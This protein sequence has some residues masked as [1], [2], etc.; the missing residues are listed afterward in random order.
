M[1]ARHRL[2]DLLAALTD[3]LRGSFLA[4]EQGKPAGRG[5]TLESLLGV[6]QDQAS[7]ALTPGPWLSEKAPGRGPGLQLPGPAL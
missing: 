7:P 5:A 6:Q 2:P 3:R 4:C 1:G